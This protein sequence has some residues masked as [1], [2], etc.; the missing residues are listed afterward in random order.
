MLVGI[1]ATNGGPH[2][3]QKWAMVT[4]GQIIQFGE[5]ADPKLREM[6]RK[7]ELRMLDVLERHH[8]TVQSKER[9]AIQKHGEDRLSHPLH[10]SIDHRN[11]AVAEH[12]DVESITQELIDCAKGTPFEAHFEQPQVRSYI[13]D[14]L[15]NHFATS[16]SIE[17]DWHADRI[18][19]KEPG[20]KM[21]LAYKAKDVATIHAA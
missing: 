11:R 10:L 15:Q 17:R 2:P 7:L 21:A 3:P 14:L 20:H 6:G 18:L 5:D 1:L 16:I 4:A 12:V 8:D 19:A 13:H 9:S